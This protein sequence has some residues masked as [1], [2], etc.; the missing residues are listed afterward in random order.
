LHYIVATSLAIIYPLLMRFVFGS[1]A[2]FLSAMVYGIAT[3]CITWFF[4]EP[5]LG[6][7]VMA[8]KTPKPRNSAGSGFYRPLLLR[9]G[10]LSWPL[11]AG[12][13]RR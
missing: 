9:I 4:I 11:V 7:G 13:L 1:P 12:A 2:G 10:H 6:V 3:I 8:S 5:A